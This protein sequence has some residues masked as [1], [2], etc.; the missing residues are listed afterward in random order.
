MAMQTFTRGAQGC[1]TGTFDHQPE[2]TFSSRV[3]GAHW[4]HH[5]HIC[6]TTVL[7]LIN[8]TYYLLDPSGNLTYRYVFFPIY[9]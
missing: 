7:R 4:I 5:Y 9:S 8:A 2:S 3:K 6:I 1:S